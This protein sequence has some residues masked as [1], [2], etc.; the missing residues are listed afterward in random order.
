MRDS[1]AIGI[2][3]RKTYTRPP[4]DVADNSYNIFA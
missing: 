2:E 1:L 4:Q 3:N